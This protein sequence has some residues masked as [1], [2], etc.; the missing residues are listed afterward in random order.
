[1]S[2]IDKF[3]YSKFPEEL[4]E[5]KHLISARKRGKKR[6]SLLIPEVYRLKRWP[7]TP[8]FVKRAKFQK[9]LVN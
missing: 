1:M 7:K 3:L 2:D 9:Y 6:S 5:L 8:F 4:E